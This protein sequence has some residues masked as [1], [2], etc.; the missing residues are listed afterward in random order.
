MMSI[1]EISFELHGDFIFDQARSFKAGS[2]RAFVLPGSK[3]IT[4]TDQSGQDR[5]EA[6]E[7][8]LSPVNPADSS[9]TIRG[10]VIGI[11]F[12]WQRREDQRFQGALRLKPDARGKLVVINDISV[13][14]YLASVI[15][16]EMSA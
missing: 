14:S 5:F 13:E 15:S 4:L 6:E 9:F 10:I 7:I 1:E 12:H 8:R 16:S 11:D 2:W 3:H